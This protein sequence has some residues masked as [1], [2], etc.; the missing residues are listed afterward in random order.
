MFASEDDVHR[1]ASQGPSLD[2]SRGFG[3]LYNVYVCIYV[4]CWVSQT[5]AC[6]ALRDVASAVA[7][8]PNVHIDGV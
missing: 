1:L 3:V 6:A 7:V 5:A 8:K 2:A 4:P